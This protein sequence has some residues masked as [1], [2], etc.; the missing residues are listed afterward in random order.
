MSIQDGTINAIILLNEGNSVK[1]LKLEK[2]E[3]FI[4]HPSD[5]SYYMYVGQGVDVEVAPV[6]AI[7]ADTADTAERVRTKGSNPVIIEGTDSGGQLKV[8]AQ[9]S[10][11]VTLITAKA[12]QAGTA[13]ADFEHIGTM[14]L[15]KGS[16]YGTREERDN[17]V[18]T[19]GQLF[20][21]VGESLINEFK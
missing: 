1:G 12:N 9:D 6:K 14:Q 18:K 16:S 10:T 19:E 7:K 21:V 11:Q 3:P 8:T 17:L 4:H 5:G 2:R 15:V 13:Q 20:F